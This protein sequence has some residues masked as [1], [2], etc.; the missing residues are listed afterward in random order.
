MYASHEED[1]ELRKEK[2]DREYE[3]VRIIFWD[4]TNVPYLYKPNTVLLQQITFAVLLT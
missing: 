1:K 4:N 2:W 3:D